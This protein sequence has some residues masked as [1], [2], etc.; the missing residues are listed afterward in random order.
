[1]ASVPARAPGFYVD[2]GAHDPVQD[3]VTKLFYDRGWRGVNVEPQLAQ[4]AALCAQRP[5]RHQPRRRDRRDRGGTSAPR[6]PR[7]QWPQHV[8]R[9]TLARHY[10]DATD[11]DVVDRE[12][13]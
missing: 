7:G 10:R 2:V 4:H 9:R 6:G 5:A 11:L 8:R 3:S 12:V 13:P 1:M